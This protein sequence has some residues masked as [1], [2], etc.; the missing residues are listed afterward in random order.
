M[1]KNKR[2]FVY[3]M[4]NRPRSHALYTGVTG[5]LLRRV[6]QHKNKLMPGFTSR[7]NLTRLVY[8]EEFVYP[9]AAIN[10]EKEIKAWRRGTKIALIASMNP[11]WDDLARTWQDVYKP[12]AAPQT[13]PSLGEDP[14][15]IPRSA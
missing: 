4:T 5:N 8:Y 12:D 2:F 7:Y 15:Q 9:D 13:I 6:F 3:I 10:R 1:P 14:R 11:Q